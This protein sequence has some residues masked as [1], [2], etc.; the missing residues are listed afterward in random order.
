MEDR[1]VVRPKKTDKKEDKSVV[2]TLRMD[3]E[4]Q[5]EFD[6]LSAKSDRSRN[7]LMCRALRYALEHLEFIPENADG[8]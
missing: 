8:E 2:M 3:R 5:E 1:F 7:E 4:L 6:H